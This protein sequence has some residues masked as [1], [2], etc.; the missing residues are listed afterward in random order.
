MQF[1]L[2]ARKRPVN[3]TGFPYEQIC[4][5]NDEQNKYY[6]LDK[7]DR[8]IYMEGMV[9]RTEWQQEPRCVLYVEFEK[10]LTKRKVR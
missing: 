1:E 9:I 6:M 10:P 5:F 7:L 3:G 8:E 4:V 2:W